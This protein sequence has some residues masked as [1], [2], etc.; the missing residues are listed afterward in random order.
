[1][2]INN[3]VTQFLL[4]HAA[5][6]YIQIC[7][8]LRLQVVPDLQA[9]PYCQKRQCAAFVTSKQYLVVWEDQADRLLER[10][11]YLQETL[12]DMM[13]KFEGPHPSLELL[14]PDDISYKWEGLHEE[15]AVSNAR[16]VAILQAF[17]TALTLIGVC[18][19]IGSGWRQVAIEIATD[20][21]WIRLAFTACILPQLWL[22][23]F[24]FQAMVGNVAQMIGPTGQVSKNTKFYSGQPPARLCR[25]TLPHVTI[26]LPV[27]KEGLKAVIDPTIRSLKAAIATYEMQGGTANIFIND[28][29][30]QVL[31]DSQALERQQYYDDNDI[32]WVARPSHNPDGQN[33]QR[34]IFNRRG[35][36]KKASNMNYAMWVSTTIEAALENIERGESWNQLDENAVYVEAFRKFLLDQKGRAWGNGN[37]RIGD[38][39]LL[40]DSDTRVPQDCLLEAVSEMEQSPSVAIIQYLSGVMNVTDNF[41]E[42]GITFFT[43]LIYTQ[44]QFAVANGDVAPFV[45][46]NA[47]LRWSAI[48]EIGY[49][50][51]FDD[52]EK[53]WSE[54]TVSEDFDM[55]LRLQASGY[56]VRLGAYQGKGFKEGVS[57][58]VYDELN[59]WEK[60]V[61]LWNE[62]SLSCL[63]SIF[64]GMLT[65][66][67]SLYSIHS[68]SGSHEDPLISYL[69]ASLL[70]VCRSH[71]NSPL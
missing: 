2:T 36:F 14:S 58:S 16:P 70:R 20:G 35:K 53:Y 55:A 7:E 48:Q 1:M 5:T 4:R 45:G 9:L 28:D 62:S 38:Y 8:G 49:H 43:N 32:G 3:R 71:R 15:D 60:Y 66:A 11:T 42:R 63:L 22:A 24:F 46:H 37:I 54:E 29:G 31:D 41:F 13:I 50:C 68:S 39:I 21:G 69:S 65:V 26:Q 33:Q 18:T 6:N 47:V 17:L 40:V 25:K 44:I 30:M 23:L 57:L 56:I 12:Y 19:A 52:C 10:A 67:M 51:E 27:Y 64:Q 34:H 59:R 61:T